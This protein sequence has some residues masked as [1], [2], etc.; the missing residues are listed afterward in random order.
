MARPNRA[1]TAKKRMK[2][3]DDIARAEY[4]KLLRKGLERLSKDIEDKNT[5]TSVVARIVEIAQKEIDKMKDE[6]AEAGIVPDKVEEKE[7]EVVQ[8][9]LIASN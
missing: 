8:I 4:P 1:E 7:S 9:S 5:A 2:E 3:I 6:D